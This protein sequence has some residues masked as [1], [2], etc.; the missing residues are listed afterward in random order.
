M[1]GKITTNMNQ[2]TLVMKRSRT[3][4]LK[5]CSK[6]TNMSKLSNLSSTNSQYGLFLPLTN[7]MGC[8]CGQRCSAGID[9]AKVLNQT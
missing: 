5:Q 6:Y 3:V 8:F 9:L 2:F 7:P 4:G 1:G